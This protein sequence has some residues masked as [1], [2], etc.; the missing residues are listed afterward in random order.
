MHGGSC[1]FS[2][3]MAG[4]ASLSGEAHCAPLGLSIGGVGLAQQDG[5]LFGLQVPMRCQISDVLGV[6][7][8]STHGIGNADRRDLLHA[9]VIHG[10]PNRELSNGREETAAPGADAARSP[11]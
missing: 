3:R 10:I 6:S 5:A 9:V 7:A 1:V 8:P 2:V 11:R 4:S